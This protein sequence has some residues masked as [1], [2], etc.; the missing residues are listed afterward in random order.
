MDAPE[1][2]PDTAY[3]A[4]LPFGHI[5]SGSRIDARGIGMCHIPLHAKVLK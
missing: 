5:G 3:S 1:K 2:I 4:A